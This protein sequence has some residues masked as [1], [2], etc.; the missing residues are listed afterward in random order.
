VRIATFHHSAFS[1]ERLAELKDGRRV[2]V[3]IPA[4]DEAETLGPILSCVQA[5][6]VSGAGLVDEV[7]VVDDG[8]T[9]ATAQV[10]EAA[11][12]RVVT[13]GPE[14]LGKGQALWRAVA[15]SS[16]DLVVFCDADVANFG[17][18]FVA[19]LLGPLLEAEEVALVK[20]F[21]QRPLNG[22]GGG[23]GR[24]SELVA[25]PL[26]ATFFPH[27]GGV[28]QPLAGETAATR[29]VLEQVAFSHGYGVELGLLI[30]VSTR[31]GVGSLAQ[32]DLGVRVHRN[33]PLEELSL[34]ALAVLQVALAR[35]GAVTGP[36]VLERPG[37]PAVVVTPGE[38]PPLGKATG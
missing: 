17:P 25:R 14:G 28:L 20:G 24:V 3:C 38:C 32:V 34:Q 23:G 16:G 35:A 1:P 9:D 6:L 29:E 37:L 22:T 33:R 11:G 18:H 36:A 26:I 7:V 30:D 8:S 19:G 12:A 2:S 5:E 10:A 13:T 15:E 4:R 31:W 21:Y 27:L